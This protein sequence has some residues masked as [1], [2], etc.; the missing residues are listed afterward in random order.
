MAWAEKDVPHFVCYYIP[1]NSVFPIS[2]N[3][4]LIDSAI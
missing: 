3:G 2:R 4:Q 1:Q